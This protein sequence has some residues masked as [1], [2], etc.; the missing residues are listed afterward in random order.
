MADYFFLLDGA[1]FEQEA[2]PA[3]TAAWRRRSSAPCQNLCTALLPA[4][5]D[6]AARY[7]LGETEP[8]L[9]HV[10]G[11]LPFERATWRFLV[12]DVLLYGEAEIPEMQ[13]CPD[14]LCRLLAPSH[15]NGESVRAR[16]SRPYP[17]SP[18]R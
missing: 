10:A 5:R 7:H 1:F 11:G 6:Y 9:S 18:H 3:L 13:T 2:R 16:A 15:S 14:T 17:A 8:L 4:A 12:A